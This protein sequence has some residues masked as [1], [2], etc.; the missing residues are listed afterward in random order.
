MGDTLEKDSS[1]W[2]KELELE[3]TEELDMERN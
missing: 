2:E 3:L 1:P